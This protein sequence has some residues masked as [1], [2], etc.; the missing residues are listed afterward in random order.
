MGV[1][2]RSVN[3]KRTKKKRAGYAPLQNRIEIIGISKSIDETYIREISLFGFKDY[4][5]GKSGCKNYR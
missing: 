3:Y 4:S 2:K 1:R 5:D